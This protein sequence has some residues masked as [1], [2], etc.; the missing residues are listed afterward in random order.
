AVFFSYVK[1]FF[2][3]TDTRE[4]AEN[5]TYVLPCADTKAR[6]RCARLIF[7]NFSKYLVDFFR[8]KALDLAYI[9]KNIDVV[10]V[11]HIDEALA[12][13]K[14]VIILS[15]HLGSWEYGGAIMGLLGYPINVVA[16]DHK[17]KLVND[18][19]VT[20]RRLKNERIIPLGIAVRK[21]FSALAHNELVAIVGDKDFT[22]SGVVV[23]FFGKDTL[24]PKGPAVFSLKT[25][26]AIVPGYM[27]RLKDDRCNLIFEEPVEYQPTGD[28]D[29][30]VVKLTQLCASRIEKYISPYPEQWYC[31]RRFFVK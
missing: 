7:A 30:D 9:R 22:N 18:F 28:F 4:M 13:K 21:C 8:F 15:A 11:N 5:L 20:Q 24:L 23:K 27:I 12:K 25:G 29:G 6:K 16:L 31:F 10:N 2:S 19:F 17:N 26:A 3:F 1:Y 14:G